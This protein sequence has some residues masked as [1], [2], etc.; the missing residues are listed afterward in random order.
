ME[1]LSFS[2]DIRPG[3]LKVTGRDLNYSNNL[4]ILKN[5]TKNYHQIKI[6]TIRPSRHEISRCSFQDD[7][8]DREIETSSSNESEIEEIKT[9]D[10]F[11]SLKNF[12]TKDKSNHEKLPKINTFIRDLDIDSE[13]KY[14]DLLYLDQAKFLISS[15]PKNSLVRC[16]IKVVKNFY[17]EYFLY[18]ED[19]ENSNEP[20]CFT[21][22]KKSLASSA[23]S[24]KTKGKNNE[25]IKLGELHSN[26]KRNKYALIGCYDSEESEFEDLN[27]EEIKNN[28]HHE[29]EK[30]NKNYFSLFFNNKMMG[31]LR[32]KEIFMEMN[33][34]QENLAI[35]TTNKIFL[36]EQLLTKRPE[37]DPE[38]KTFIMDFNGRAE[39]PSTNNIQL[40]LKD[41][42]N[43]KVALQIGKLKEKTY[44]LDF[45]YPFSIFSAFGLAVSCLS[46]N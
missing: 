12:N 15:C 45:S 38:S 43:K 9:D 7:D 27:N 11:K 10:S 22:R 16:K 24:F 44:S 20:L 3:T 18:L 25:V 28:N 5:E 26:L 19:K 46:H 33:M 40:I 41:D 39:L 37:Y 1:I 14:F 36:K 2:N 17:T 4:T 31:D 13:K 8:D 21:R 34:Y 35:M 42:T 30:L 32:P 29:S 6:K 23:Y